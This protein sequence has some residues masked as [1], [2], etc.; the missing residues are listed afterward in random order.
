MNAQLHALILAGGSGTRFWPW[1]RRKAPKQFLA[2]D[3][4]Q[5]MLDA[6]L[7]RLHGFVEEE[8]RWILTRADLAAAVTTTL[9]SFPLGR[10]LSEPE[11]RDTAP[12][13]VLGAWRIAREN[14]EALLLVLP[15]DHHI[16]DLDAFQATMN[17]AISAIEVDDGLYTFGI[18]PHEPATGFGYIERGAETTCSDV[19]RVAKFCEKP[20]RS[21]AA[22]FVASGG[23]YWNS[24]IFLWR[25][26][27]F[28]EELRSVAPEFGAGLDALS[29]LTSDEFAENQFLEAFQLLPSTSIDYA[30]LERSQRVRVVDANFTWDDVGTWEAVSRL[31]EGAVDRH[32]NSLDSGTVA[33]DSRDNVTVQVAPDRTVVLLGV[34]NLLVVDTPDALL[35]CSRD[36]PQDVKDVVERL[37]SDGRE[38]LV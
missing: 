15:S 9:E 4:R 25:A 2:L 3:G 18:T 35:V 38:D 34:E 17:R 13:L 21:T 12:A 8:N 14:P 31:R 11:G 33:V 10:I 7:D 29:S 24:G 28:L 20:N 22:E 5:C 36:R 6:T 19:Y 26:T 32:G 37:L 30:L 23:Y 27:T 1:S 16:E